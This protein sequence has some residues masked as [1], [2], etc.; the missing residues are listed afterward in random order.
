MQPIILV[1]AGSGATEVVELV[2]DI[3]GAKPKYEI[4][5]IVDDDMSKHGQVIDGVEVVGK[6]EKVLDHPDAGLVFCMGSYKGRFIRHSIMER[7][8]VDL[9]RFINLV[10]PLAKVYSSATLGPGAIVHSG[11]V[12]G[13]DTVLR[14]IN[15]I[16]WNTAIGAR[17][18]LGEGV[19]VS[20]NATTNADVTI[21]AYS[22]V[23][24]ASV[25]VDGL[26]LGPGCLIASG[27]TVLRDVQPGVFQMGMPP[28]VISREEVPESVLTKWNSDA[29]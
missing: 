6:I 16:H 27:D 22:F 24:S 5:G 18:D 23:G 21:G 9:N 17:N 26:K 2:R 1:G 7:V 4:V 14:G 29:T 11:A 15:I 20:P 28:R 12:V 3:N 10:H 13:P 25:V 8:G 19:I